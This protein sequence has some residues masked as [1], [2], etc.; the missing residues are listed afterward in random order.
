M[1]NGQHAKADSARPIRS[2]GVLVNFPISHDRPPASPAPRVGDLAVASSDSLNDKPWQE[3][4]LSGS[5]E[6]QW[7]D[8]TFLMPP[9]ITG[10]GTD[11]DPEPETVP[12]PVVSNDQPSENPN[13]GRLEQN[14][15]PADVQPDAPQI[16]KSLI[17]PA[18]PVQPKRNWL[19][20]WLFPDADGQDKRGGERKPAPGLIAHFWTGGPPKSQPV[21]DI[22]ATGMY[23][24]TEERWYLGT[25]IRIT[26]TKTVNDGPQTE[27]SITVMATAVRWGND[28]VGLEFVQESARKTGEQEPLLSEGADSEELD[29]FVEQFG[30]TRSPRPRNRRAPRR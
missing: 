12:C 4:L 21:R 3:F 22:S 16:E 2:G 17:Q 7:D 26:L 1:S 6:K 27:Q 20:R 9:R 15:T 28:G 14:S 19:E 11:P 5:E 24:V 29:Q 8:Q 18:A 23:V 25:Q 13:P 10:T 30:A